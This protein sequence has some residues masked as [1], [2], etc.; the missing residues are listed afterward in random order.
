M[1]SFDPHINP[2]FVADFQ[3]QIDVNMKHANLHTPNTPPP[4]LA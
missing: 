3:L 1:Q 2:G 4:K